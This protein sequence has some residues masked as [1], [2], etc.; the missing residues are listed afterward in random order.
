MERYLA[1]S[2]ARQQFLKLVAGPGLRGRVPSFYDL[3]NPSYLY[4]GP[5]FMVHYRVSARDGVEFVNLFR[6]VR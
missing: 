1:V 4:R 6:C 5:S 2:E 3:Q